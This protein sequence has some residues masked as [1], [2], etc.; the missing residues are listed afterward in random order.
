M[1]RA[2]SSLA[3]DP[4]ELSTVPPFIARTRALR[5]PNRPRLDRNEFPGGTNGYTTL[6]GTNAHGKLA[7]CPPSRR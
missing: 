6:W 3:W 2:D 7:G 1:H 4:Y 5:L